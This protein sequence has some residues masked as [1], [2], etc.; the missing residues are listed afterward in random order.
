MLVGASY[1][2]LSCASQTAT[3]SPLVFVHGPLKMS[4]CSAARF[5][6]SVNAF[7]L[8]ESAESG[9]LALPFST[10]FDV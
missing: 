4:F 6:E 10:A 5:N 8:V 3:G 2:I 9:G 7:G 1:W